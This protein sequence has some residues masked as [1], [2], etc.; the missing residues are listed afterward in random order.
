MY[1]VT[2]RTSILCAN[3]SALPVEC[4]GVVPLEKLIKQRPVADLRLLFMGTMGQC[5]SN[6]T[7][8]MYESIWHVGVKG[9]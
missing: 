9:A 4:C 3:I 2:Q 1:S 8:R 7:T 5:N 6:A